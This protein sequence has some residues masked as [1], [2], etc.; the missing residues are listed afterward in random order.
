ME[1]SFAR[2]SSKFSLRSLRIFS[3]SSELTPPRAPASISVCG[4]QFAHPFRA[5]SEKLVLRLPPHDDLEVVKVRILAA[6][7]VTCGTSMLNGG[8]GLVVIEVLRVL[9]VNPVSRPRVGTLHEYAGSSH[10]PTL[11]RAEAE[12]DG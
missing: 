8:A 11:P 5:R 1:I 3:C 7:F 4:S 2:G 10:V 6:P 12:T 9:A